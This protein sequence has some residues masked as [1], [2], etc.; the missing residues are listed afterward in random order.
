[1]DTNILMRNA[2]KPGCVLNGEQEKYVVESVLGAGGFGITYEVSSEIVHKNIKVKA[3][4]ALKE[5]FLSDFCE[6]DE[7]TGMVKYMASAGEKVENSIKDFIGEANRLIRIGKNHPNIVKVNEIFRANGTAYYVMEYL[8]GETLADCIKRKGSLTEQETMMI[9]RPVM[10]AVA[11]L[12]K[13]SLTHLDIK[14]ENIMLTGNDSGL[15]P[16]LIDFGLA[17]HYDKKGSPTSTINTLGCSHGYSPAEQYAGITV[18]SPTADIYALGATLFH[19][20]TGNMPAKSTELKPGQLAGLLKGVAPAVRDAVLHAMKPFPDER[21]QSADALMA[22]LSDGTDISGQQ[23]GSTTININI[24]RPKKE[25]VFLRKKMAVGLMAAVVSIA[26]AIWI[27]A[28]LHNEN[29]QSSQDVIAAAHESDSMIAESSEPVAKASD[30]AIEAAEA[31]KEEEM[32]QEELKKQE[33]QRKEDENNKL[34]E[35]QDKQDAAALAKFEK[36]VNALYAEGNALDL[37]NNNRYQYNRDMN[38]Y[39]YEWDDDERISNFNSKAGRLMGTKEWNKF[40]S[41]SKVANKCSKIQS[42]VKRGKLIQ[43]LAAGWA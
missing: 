43:S 40:K 7:A 14:P 30:G 29:R 33:E 19:C 1:M 27:A 23:P 16:V 24:N 2:L 38:C 28:G 34:K 10:E 41:N 17:K 15:R 37:Y 35:E 6:R 12:H 5:H 11:E 42:L 20:L 26:A 4:F 25:K 21:T 3:R 32:R 31:Q 8:E 39:G 36:Q 22:E 13:S 9:M 18:F